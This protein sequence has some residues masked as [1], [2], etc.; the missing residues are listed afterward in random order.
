MPEG[1][2]L[3]KLARY[4]SPRLRGQLLEPI[5]VPNAPRALIVDDDEV[6]EVFAR[7]K[8]LLIQ[9]GSGRCLRVHLGMNGTF[10]HYRHHVRW[11]RSAR[12]AQVVLATQEDVFVCF[13]PTKV[14]LSWST[15]PP[16]VR[17]LGPD[18]ALGPPD[19]QILAERL[20]AAMQRSPR[21]DDVLLDQQICSG[22][23]NVYKSEILFIGQ[24]SPNRPIDSLS[25]SKVLELFDIGSRL[26]RDNLEGGPRVTTRSGLN[27]LDPN[28]SNLWVYGRRNLPCFRCGHL[29]S[30]AI[31]GRQTRVTYWCTQCQNED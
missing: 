14:E 28:G 11:K 22:I 9:L 31:T 16:S 10:H 3:H 26:L 12:T 17:A 21:L 5:E 24:V 19:P 2:T 15:P 6:E 29:I 25:E 13:R 18:L 4:L 30:R 1:D 7:G 20:K 23:G 8:H 27:Q